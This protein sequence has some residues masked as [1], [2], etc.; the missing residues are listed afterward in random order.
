[1]VPPVRDVVFTTG[2]PLG[3]LSAWGVFSLYHHILVQQA[4]YGVDKK[5]QWF[6]N[7]AILGDDLVIGCPKV[8]KRYR[9]IMRTLGVQISPVKPLCSRSGSMEFASRFILRGIDLSPVSFKALAARQ[10]SGYG[11]SSSV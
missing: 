6:T 11:R 4:A 7:Y 9:R 8:A 5:P 2:T 10:S 1:M 3:S